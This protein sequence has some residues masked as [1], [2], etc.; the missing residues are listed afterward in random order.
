MIADDGGETADLDF[1]FGN[2]VDMFKFQAT[3]PSWVPW[4]GGGPVFPAIWNI[5]DF[6]ITSGVILIFIRQKKYFPKEKTS[7]HQVVER[8]ED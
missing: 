3:W 4:L 7:K 6:A 1:V 8:G 5:A 2:V